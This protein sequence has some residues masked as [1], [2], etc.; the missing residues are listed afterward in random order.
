[1][2]REIIVHLQA[3]GGKDLVE[4][5]G[6]VRYQSAFRADPVDFRL[7]VAISFA[8]EAGRLA[9]HSHGMRRLTGQHRWIT[10]KF[11]K[12]ETRGVLLTL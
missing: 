2:R 5:P 1:M 10:N 7:R 3:C 6:A 9:L 8:L 12:G 4:V 11:L